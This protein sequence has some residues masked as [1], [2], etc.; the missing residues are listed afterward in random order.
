M[1]QTLPISHTPIL[2]STLSRFGSTGARG[3]RPQGPGQAMYT[4]AEN[5]GSRNVGKQPPFSPSQDHCPLPE[6]PRP[7]RKYI[8]VAAPERPPSHFSQQGSRFSSQVFMSRLPEQ[9]LKRIWV[10]SDILCTFPLRAETTA[11]EAA[12]AGSRDTAAHHG[13][14]TAVPGIGALEKNHLPIGSLGTPPGAGCFSQS[15]RRVRDQDHARIWYENSWS[16]PYR[17]NNGR[18]T[19]F[20][21][22]CGHRGELAFQYI[23]D[24]FFLL[25]TG[26]S[27]QLSQPTVLWTGILET[28]CLHHAHTS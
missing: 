19:C 17:G 24:E 23:F 4:Y 3:E 9:R 14:K 25:K 16:L 6:V 12:V 27:S 20:L 2:V 13:G 21:R 5:L 22:R 1:I 26:P 10:P 28:R 11:A 18:A 15:T 8:V 7:I